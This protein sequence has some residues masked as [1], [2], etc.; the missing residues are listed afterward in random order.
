MFSHDLLEVILNFFQKIYIGADFLT[1]CL[2]I[3]S[4]FF[5]DVLIAY[6]YIMELYPF[7]RAWEGVLRAHAHEFANACT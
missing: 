2:Y 4:R 1:S 5:T 6:A 7:I 3:D